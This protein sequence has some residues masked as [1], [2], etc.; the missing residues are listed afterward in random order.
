[1]TTRG[2]HL[3]M[4]CCMTGAYCIAGP[5]MIGRKSRQT[6]TESKSLEVICGRLGSKFEP[7]PPP[8]PPPPPRL[9]QNQIHRRHHHHPE[10]CRLPDPRHSVPNSLQACRIPSY[11]HH[12]HHHPVH[13]IKGI[14]TCVETV[15]HI[16]A[17]LCNNHTRLMHIPWVTQEAEKEAQYYV[18]W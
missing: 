11:C 15:V 9:L 13:A 10:A 8:P 12:L 5:K 2:C 7:P 4:C 17:K 1:M 18:S 3:C 6:L 14:A 16:E